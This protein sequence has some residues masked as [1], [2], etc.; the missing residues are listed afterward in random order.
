MVCASEGS[1]PKETTHTPLIKPM[2]ILINGSTF[3]VRTFRKGYSDYVDQPGLIQNQGTEYMTADPKPV[4]WITGTKNDD[5]VT[6]PSQSTHKWVLKGGGGNDYMQGTDRNMNWM[7][8][9]EGDDYIH[10]SEHFKD[11]INGGTGNDKLF[12]Y[13]GTD[14]LIGGDG[15]DQMFGGDGNDKLL[16]GKGDDQLQG[17]EGDDLLLAGHGSNMYYGEAGADRFGLMKQHDQNIIGDFDHTEGDQLLIRKRNIDSVEVSHAGTGS[18][19]ESQF[20]LKSDMGLT[21]IQTNAGTTAEDIIGAIKA[22]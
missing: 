12:G 14:K 6:A 21:G 5:Y 1:N 8:G 9:H 20:W 3:L 11:Y 15:D 2:S 13:G 22:I 19:G 7:F 10:G 16:G 18:N 4:S 17:G